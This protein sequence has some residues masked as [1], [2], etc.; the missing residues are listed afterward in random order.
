M[1]QVQRAG[2]AVRLFTRRDYDWSGRY[3]SIAVTV[4]RLCA[5]TLEAVVFADVS[6]A[7]NERR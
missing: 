2:D 7:R 6:D 3:P 5:R 4:A 1:M